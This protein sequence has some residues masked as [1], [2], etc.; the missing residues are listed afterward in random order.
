VS[1]LEV[2]WSMI[3]D[4]RSVAGKMD[5]VKV[6]A[7]ASMQLALRGI[8]GGRHLAAKRRKKRKKD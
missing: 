1:D 2:K 6:E 4:A 3:C 8:E 5:E 7:P